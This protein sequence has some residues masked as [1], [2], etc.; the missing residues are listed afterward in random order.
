MTLSQ[1]KAWFGL[2]ICYYVKKCKTTNKNISD[3]IKEISHI[4]EDILL[5]NLKYKEI[6]RIFIYVINTKI[7]NGLNNEIKF[8]SELHPYS[9]FVLAYEFNKEQIKN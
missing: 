1:F 9:P 5:K 3:L 7:F 2:I 6:I 8:V 4:F